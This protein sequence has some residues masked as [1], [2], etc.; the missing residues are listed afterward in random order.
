MKKITFILAAAAALAGMSCTREQTPSDLPGEGTVILSVDPGF[1]ATRATPDVSHYA[2]YE[3]QVKKTDIL[4]FD[5]KGQL[6]LLYPAGT[7]LNN[8][9]LSLPSGAKQIWAVVNGPDLSGIFR[10]DDLKAQLISLGD[11]STGT[12]GAFIMAGSNTCTVTA[13]GTTPCTVTVSRFAARIT[14]TKVEAK[15]P[16]AYT[17]IK[18][19]NAM[20]TNVVENQ[21]LEGSASPDSW[22][23][24]MGR[25]QAGNIIGATASD[26]AQ[27]EDLTFRRLDYTLS[28]NARLSTPTPIC[29]YGMPNP[30]QTDNKPN[31]SFVAERT[32]VVVTA[33]I[34]GQTYY[35]PVSIAPL[36]RNKTYEVE[37]TITGLGSTDPDVLPEKGSSGITVTV[38]PWAPGTVV[39]ETI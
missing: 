35:Y 29:F 27:L 10:L 16:A 1:A 19:R 14:L 22:I 2:A 21:N 5:E 38:N 24:Q 8:I 31:G 30:T 11:N 20:L 26:V 33:E 37:L 6:N 4:V 15:L 12:S 3:Y 25:T 36:E 13:A 34:G 39:E 9:S 18:I 32:R 17:E 28:N 23:N 7:T